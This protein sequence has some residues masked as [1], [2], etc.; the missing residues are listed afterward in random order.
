MQRGIPGTIVV[1][2]RSFIQ[3]CESKIEMPVLDRQ[4]DLGHEV[5]RPFIGLQ[6]ELDPGAFRALEDS[7]LLPRPPRPPRAAV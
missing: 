7:A 2:I 4:Q 1:R 3:K 5:E 6:R